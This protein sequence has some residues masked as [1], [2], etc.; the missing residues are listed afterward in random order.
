MSLPGNPEGCPDS[1]G[2]ICIT[3]E[4]ARVD[5]IFGRLYVG[6]VEFFRA[7]PREWGRPLATHCTG[8]V[9]PRPCSGNDECQA[10]N[11]ANRVCAGERDKL[12]LAGR[13]K[14]GNWEYVFMR[15]HKT[16]LELEYDR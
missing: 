1:E 10:A 7:H 11:N 14:D 8:F 6:G 4:E 15:K 16:P 13:W 9:G 12:Q 5:Q 3:R 2:C